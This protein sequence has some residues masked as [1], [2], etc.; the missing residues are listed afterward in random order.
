V[1]DTV[2]PPEPALPYA[3]LVERM[4]RRSNMLNPRWQYDRVLLREAADAIRTLSE[5]LERKE[6]K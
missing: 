2:K 4:S 6:P 3:E 1:S 5:Q